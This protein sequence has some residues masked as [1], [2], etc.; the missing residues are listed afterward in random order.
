MTEDEA[1][2]LLCDERTLVA[3]ETAQEVQ[4]GD[5]LFFDWRGRLHVARD[6][7]DF[8]TTYIALHDAKKGFPVAVFGSDWPQRSQ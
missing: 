6:A 8:T 1:I 2:K 3:N 4:R 5:V 7:N